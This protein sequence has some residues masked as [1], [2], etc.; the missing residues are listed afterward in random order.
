MRP[1]VPL[2]TRLTQGNKR[3][4]K[5]RPSVPLAKPA[6]RPQ[7]VCRGCWTPVSLGRKR[8]GECDATTTRERMVE[9]AKIGRMTAH[10]AGPLARLADTRRRHASA[11]RAWKPSSLPAWLDEDT[12]TR[13]I[14]PLLAGIAN[15]VIMSALGVSVTYAVAIRAS[16]RRPHPRHWG[17]LAELVGIFEGEKLI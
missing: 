3:E 17:A 7:N 8:C 6:P 5:G 16:R 1:D 13:K 4:A 10:A 2:A 15:P 14:Q 12:Y 9:V 11:I